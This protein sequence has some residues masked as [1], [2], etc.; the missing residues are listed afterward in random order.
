[1]RVTWKRFP[2]MTLVFWMVWRMSLRQRARG[3]KANKANP[4]SAILAFLLELAEVD[5]VGKTLPK[6]ELIERIMTATDDQL[7]PLWNNE[8]DFAP[9]V[10]PN[11][12]Q[13]EPG[14]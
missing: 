12:K 5:L 4:R 1:M 14:S 3:P 8:P 11:F 2:K 9:L 6:W 10:H 7:M 13:S